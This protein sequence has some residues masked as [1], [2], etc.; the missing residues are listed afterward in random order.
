MML[1]NVRRWLGWDPS[2]TAPATLIH[3]TGPPHG[4]PTDAPLP[5][6]TAWPPDRLEITNSLWGKG[7]QFPGGENETLHLARPLG[8]S[9]ASSLILIGAGSGGPPCAVARNFGSWAT[10]FESDPD[11]RAAASDFA[12]H[13]GLARRAQIESWDPHDPDFG[14]HQFHQGLAL[15]PLRHGLPEQT[16]DALARAIKPGGQFVLVETVADDPLDPSDPSVST[17]QRL[18]HRE[19]A[20]LHSETAITRVLS[21]LAFDVRIVEDIT[22]R[23]LSQAVAAWRRST[24]ALEHTRPSNRMASLLVREAELWL[25]SIRLM[26]DHRLRRMRWHVTGRS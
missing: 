15:E 4:R 24:R 16:L 11:L 26:R 25:V 14:S 3:G 1:P 23:H 5:A 10:G 13:A 9:G 20:Q 7:F 12:L 2:A 8:L 17:W 22:Q 6:F 18:D 21:R 19:A